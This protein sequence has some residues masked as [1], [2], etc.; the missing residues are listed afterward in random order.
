VI[1]MV[2][3]LKK[4]TNK[5]ELFT[6]GHRLCAGCGIA[7]IV[8]Q[9]LMA[10]ENPV[11]ISNATGCLEVGTTIYPYT[12]WKVPW[13]H[14]AF[15]NSAATISGIETVY[16]ALKEE[17]KVAED[18]RFIAIGGDGGTYDIGLQALSGALERGHNFTYICYDNEAYMNTGMQ[19][20]SASPRGSWTTTTPV[21]KNEPGKIIKK[22]PLT[23]IVVAH[24][25]PYVAQAAP[26]HWRDLMNKVQKALATE[27]PSFL[28]ILQPCV[29]GW[30]IEPYISMKVAKLAVETCNWP[31]YEVVNGTYHVTVKPKEKKP[32]SEY[33][34]PQGR[35]RH[36]LTD[37]NKPLLDELQSEVDANWRELLAKSAPTRETKES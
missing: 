25:I 26:G 13:I 28:N 1:D 10:V 24:R 27:G 37:E 29:P 19:R 18:I 6:N 5:P 20:S 36:L 9:V 7:T 2:V 4:F 30:R 21:G 34:E 32:L 17:G 12:S 22:K 14:S 16:R 31:L 8:R 3:N 11:V 15:E 23:D 33:L 35:F